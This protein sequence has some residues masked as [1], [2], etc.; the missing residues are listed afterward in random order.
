VF[1]YRRRRLNASDRP[2]RIDEAVKE[3]AAQ[4]GVL[5]GRSRCALD[6]AVL[7]DAVA[8]QDTVTRLV[9]AIRK[10]RKLVPAAR[11]VHVTAHDYDRGGKPDIAWDDEVARDRL[12]SALVTDA[13]AIIDWLPVVGLDDEAERAVALVA[14][15][16]VE[17]GETPGEWRIARAVAKDLRAHDRPLVA[18]LDEYVEWLRAE[19]SGYEV[20]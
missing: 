18:A 7:D 9:A 12:V 17:S 1:V 16:D 15:Q 4:T 13:L 19:A 14:G 2:H 8:T 3:L 10:V 20:A 11:E 5:N 6:P